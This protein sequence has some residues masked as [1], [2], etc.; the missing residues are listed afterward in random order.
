MKIVIIIFAIAVAF[1]TAINIYVFLDV[2]GR[3]PGSA[4]RILTVNESQQLAKP[5]DNVDCIIVLGAA[6]KDGKPCKMLKDRL[7]TGLQIY[8]NKVSDTILL[9]GDNGSVEYNEVAA[10]DAYVWENGEKYGVDFDKIY[11][12]YAGFSTYESMYRLRDVFGAKKAVVVTQKYHLYRAV[13][14]GKALGIDVY[15]V[16]TP[17]TEDGQW[18]R[19]LREYFA[20][21]KDFLYV[22]FDKKPTFLGEAI[23]LK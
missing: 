1:M 14:D 12:D 19:S 2:T 8:G 3:L 16:I 9:S 21:V 5:A 4:D 11:E 10:M 13:Y 7:D 6:V 20:I 15:G 18:Y 17:P 22:H 23:N